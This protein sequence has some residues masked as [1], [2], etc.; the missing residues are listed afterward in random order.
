MAR[1]SVDNAY[2]PAAGDVVIPG[3]TA[4]DQFGAAVHNLGALCGETAAEIV[5]AWSKGQPVSKEHIYQ[6]FQ[7]MERAGLTVG[8]KHAEGVS[9]PA[10][11]SRQLTNEGVSNVVT[12]NWLG[13]LETYAGIR[14]VLLDVQSPTHDLGAANQLAGD[15]R[16]VT[17]HFIT[18]EGY[19]PTHH[20]YVVADSDN[21][22]AKHQKLVYYTAQQLKNA[23]AG[24]AIVPTG[25]GRGIKGNLAG[26][27]PGNPPGGT[28]GGSLLGPGGQAIVGAVTGAAGSGNPLD[29]NTWVTAI[30][31]AL[32][33]VAAR[34]GIYALAGLAILLGI[35]L[36]F[37][38][39][40]S[41]GAQAGA[42]NAGQAAKLGELL[43]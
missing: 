42:Q 18:V 26:G 19:S 28:V 20:A 43:A 36:V 17:G 34:A 3:A 2:S 30:G 7:E 11:L 35:L 8:P 9:T 5:S 33:P 15:E 40:I 4:I 21:A 22:A 13:A 38:E 37:W 6:R 16:G 10:T 27:G 1:L 12:R 39:P 24:A 23:G 31:D 29:P 14:P 32:K 41:A 25:S